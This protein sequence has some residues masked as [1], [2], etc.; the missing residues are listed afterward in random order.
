MPDHQQP[1]LIFGA[2]GQQ[3]GSVASALLKT[4][5][6]VRAFVRNLGSP[7]SVALHDAGAELVQGD[8]ADLGSIRSAM[9][10]AHG[11]F[12]VQPSSGQGA[13]YGVSDEDEVRYGTTIADIASESSVHHLVTAPAT[14]LVISRRGW[15]TSTAR[16]ASKRMCEPCLSLH[17]LSVPRRSWRC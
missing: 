3:G 9:R 7:R 1:I 16:L 5:W 15:A 11:V 2:T 10:G 6:R 13:L 17:P 8:L 14:P 12:S 4:G